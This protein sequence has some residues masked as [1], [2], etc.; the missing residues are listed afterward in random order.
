MYSLTIF[1][2]DTSGA[3]HY[4]LISDKKEDYSE[5][6]LMGFSEPEGKCEIRHGIV[7]PQATTSLYI[8]A[9]RALKEKAPVTL[10]PPIQMDAFIESKSRTLMRRIC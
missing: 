2:C 1:R 5:E 10:N 3:T 4:A 8:K 7:P 9:L 6:T